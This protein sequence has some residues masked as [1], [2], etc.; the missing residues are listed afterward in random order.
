MD[1]KTV[2][3]RKKV[4]MLHRF[5]LHQK[6]CQL[7]SSFSIF[8]HKYTWK[9]FDFMHLH[10]KIPLVQVLGKK[11]TIFRRHFHLRF[12]N[13]PS[14][15]SANYTERT[16]QCHNFQSGKSTQGA[17]VHFW[18]ISIENPVTCVHRAGNH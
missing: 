4:S 13:V 5:Q 8:Q 6:L 16:L 11:K 10:I 17:E 1:N 9:S 3:E 15:C 2:E 18:I 12:L 7:L 14:V